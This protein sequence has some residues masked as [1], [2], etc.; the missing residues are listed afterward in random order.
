MKPSLSSLLLACALAAANSS[1]AAS[2]V[3]LSSGFRTCIDI[4]KVRL[5]TDLMRTAWD[6]LFRQRN[7]IEAAF[8]G[9]IKPGSLAIDAL[10]PSDPDTAATEARV[11]LTGRD[12]L[13]GLPILALSAIT[14]E[15]GC[16]LS[17][18]TL[19][20]GKLRLKDKKRLLAWVRTAPQ[21]IWDTDPDT[22]IKVQFV[23]N[24]GGGVSLVCD[25]ST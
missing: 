23:E 10:D 8:V 24:P 3:S 18:W 6:P 11:V 15:G 12:R 7:S 5:M 14:C 22:P 20:L 17:I 13:L 16:G 21:T 1:Y 19:E 2:A 4:G 9:R 25:T